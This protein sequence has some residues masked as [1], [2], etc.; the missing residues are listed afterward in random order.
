[1]ATTH[2]YKFGY[3]STGNDTYRITWYDN[4]STVV[5]ESVYRIVADSTEEL[6][7]AIT[8]NAMALRNSNSKLFAEDEPEEGRDM[9]METEVT[10]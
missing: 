7:K 10:D 9:M 4:G 6:E 5:C 1:M 3:V 8:L 2:S